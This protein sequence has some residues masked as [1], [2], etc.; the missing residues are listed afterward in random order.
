VKHA[1]QTVPIET[2]QCN[3]LWFLK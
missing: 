3:P 2:I 1:Q